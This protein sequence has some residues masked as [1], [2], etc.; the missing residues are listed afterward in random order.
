MITEEELEYILNQDYIWDRL[1][2]GKGT[3]YETELADILKRHGRYTE[4]RF[5]EAKKLSNKNRIAAGKIP[6]FPELL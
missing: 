5:I 1:L 2:E 3:D 6:L 4:E